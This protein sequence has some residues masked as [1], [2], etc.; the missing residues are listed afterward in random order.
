M[1]M[2]EKKMQTEIQKGQWGEDVKSRGEESAELEQISNLCSDALHH[3][4][5][6]VTI[7]IPV[8]EAGGLGAF[9]QMAD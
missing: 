6:A 5:K 3:L 7:C 2:E 8:S 9:P 4:S 1:E